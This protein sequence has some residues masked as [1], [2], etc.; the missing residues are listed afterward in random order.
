[1]KLRA[2]QALRGQATRNDCLFHPNFRQQKE[3]KKIK[4]YPNTDWHF[5]PAQ[6]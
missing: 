4:R 6:M 5:C 1:M 3:N 2:P